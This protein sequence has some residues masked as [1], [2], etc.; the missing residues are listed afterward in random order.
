MQVLFGALR[1]CRRV[2]LQGCVRWLDGSALAVLAG[3]AATLTAFDC[4]HIGTVRLTARACATCQ[5][6]FGAAVG[7]HCGH[8][9]G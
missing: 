1:C 7:R 9:V 8:A 2:D 3:T 5:Q 4:E 6:G